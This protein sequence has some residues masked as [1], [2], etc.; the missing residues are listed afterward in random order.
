[1]HADRLPNHVAIGQA[2]LPCLI[3]TEP[4]CVSLTAELARA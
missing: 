3:A 2:T 1:M 4:D